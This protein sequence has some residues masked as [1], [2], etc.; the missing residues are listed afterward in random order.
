[1]S[2]HGREVVHF[3]CYCCCILLPEVAPVSWVP[4][5]SPLGSTVRRCQGGTGDPRGVY[6]FYSAATLILMYIIKAYSSRALSA[7]IRAIRFQKI[8]GNPDGIKMGLHHEAL[9]WLLVF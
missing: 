4:L 3:Y 6:V 2:T 5:V 9:A 8:L 7:G 1:M